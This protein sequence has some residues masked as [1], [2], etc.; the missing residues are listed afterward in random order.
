MSTLCGSQPSPEKLL[1]VVDGGKC[2]NSQMV[3]MQRISIRGVL[4]HR[5]NLCITPIK[6]QG[7]LS[8]RIQQED[9]KS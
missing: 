1:H 8:Q 7:P 9:H 4:N 3:K 2:E 6:T 5:W